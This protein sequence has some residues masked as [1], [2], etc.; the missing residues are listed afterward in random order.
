MHIEVV[1]NNGSPYLKLARSYRG[2]NSRGIR[3]V[4]KQIVLNIGPLAKFD[5][6]KPDYLG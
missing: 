3:T 6:K 2:T 1:N 4:L 5:D